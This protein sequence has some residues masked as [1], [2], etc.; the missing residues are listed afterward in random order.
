VVYVSGG[1]L[2]LLDSLEPDAGPRRVEVRLGGA[3]VGLQRK[4]L[5]IQAGRQEDISEPWV[6]AVSD[7]APDQTGRASAVEVRGTIHWL[8]HRDGPVRALADSPGV[9]RRLPAVLGDTGRV[10]WVTD[11]GG[12]DAIEVGA[13]TGGEPQTLVAAGKVE[14]HVETRVDPPGLDQRI[15]PAPVA[16]ARYSGLRTVQGGLVWLRQPSRG[17]LGDDLPRLGEEPPRA[18]LEH[19][20][21]ATGK[22]QVLADSVDAVHVSGD[23]LRLVVRDKE[24]LRVVPASEKVEKDDDPRV[25]EV[26]LDRLRPRST[27]AAEWTQMYHEAWRLMRDHFWREDMGGVDWAA[28]RDRYA[29]MLDRIASHDDLVD[30]IWEM[31]GELESSHA[32]VMPPPPADRPGTHQGLLGADLSFADGAWRVSRVVPGESSE[33]RARSPLT[34]PSVVVGLG[35]AIVAVDGRPTSRTQGPGSLLVGTADKPVELTI[36][37]AGGDEAR[38]VVVVPLADE[39]PLRYQDWVDDRRAY[40]HAQTDG[41]IG[42]LHVPDMMSGGWDVNRGYEPVSYP[43]EARRGPMVCLTDMYAGS[44]GDIVTA[45]IK[46]LGLGPVVGTRTWGGVIGIDARYKLV[47]GTTVTQPRFSFWFEQFGWGVENYGVDPDIEV[48]AAPHDRVAGNDVQLDRA[49]RLV[50][51]QLAKTPASTPPGLPPL[52]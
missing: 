2:F 46:A 39:F 22:K 42:Y 24:A 17:E 9:R 6:G 29:P 23:G 15:V 43:E 25:I 7:I 4:P 35:D 48:P 11:K 40:V 10:V 49:L 5:T 8:T 32:Y 12:D 41:R 51:Q 45:A 33:P 16:G 36:I 27:P 26:D 38:A 37:P 21:L 28:A 3:R 18:A 19:L 52:T 30:L 13:T 1:S 50:E 31:H 47:D 14:D 44:D 20:D 34:A